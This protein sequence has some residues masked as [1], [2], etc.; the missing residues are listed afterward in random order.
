MSSKIVINKRIKGLQREDLEKLSKNELVDKIV[1]LEAYN[2][3]LKNILHKKLN[4]ATNSKQNEMLLKELNE[5]QE[6]SVFRSNECKKESANN[7]NDEEIEIHSDKK[8][9]K[10]Q[11]DFSK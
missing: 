3:Q 7:K 5:L 2:F 9:K 1:Q 11:F 10:R 6:K 8:S 4:D